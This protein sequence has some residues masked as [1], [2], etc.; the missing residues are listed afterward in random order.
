[1]A[2]LVLRAA[3]AAIG[4]LF[5]PIGS[6]VGQAI[7]ALG[8]YAIDRALIDS[9]RRIEGPRLTGAR[10]FAAEEGAAIPRLYGEARLGGLLIWATRFEETR[11]TSRQGGKGGPRVSEYSY[12]ANVAFALCEGPIAGVRRVWADGKEIDRETVEM[13]VHTGTHDQP[14]DPLIEA[15]QGT[16]N[17]PAYRGTAYV[18]I[19]RF[20]LGAYGNRIPQ[21]QF[22]VLRPVASLPGKVKAVALIPGATEFGLAPSPAT[23][24]KRPGETDALNRHVLHGATDLSASLDEL[25]V[26]CP[27][28]ERVALVA[29][30]FGDDLR[31]GS[32]RVRPMVTG[33]EMEGFS[34]DW[35]VSSLGRGDAAVVSMH[36]GGSAYGG[37]PSD[38]SVMEA[39]AEIR[40]R[41][42][43]VALYPFIMMDIPTANTLP[44]PYGDPAQPAYPW[45][46]RI[47]CDPAPGRPG[48]ADKTGAARDQVEAFV[49]G[50]TPADFIAG[51][52]TIAFGGD[53]DDW[54]YRRFILHFAKLAAAAGGVDAF[55]IGTELR[56][57]TTLRDDE[58]AFP[59]VEALCALA[60]DVR[61][62]VGETTSITYGAD[63]SEYFGYHPADGSGDALFHLDALWAHDA[64]DAVGIDNY[65]PLSDWRDADYGG[66]NP[67]GLTEPYDPA[68]LRAAIAGGEGFDWY[69][70]SDAD[71]AARIRTPI[72]DGAYSKPWMFR[73]KDLRSWWSS[74]HFDRLGGVEAATATSWVPESKPIWFTELGCPAAD[75]APNQPNVFPDPKSVESAVPYFSD[76]GRSDIAQQRFFAVHIDHWNPDA[77]GFAGD[78][79]PVS[80]IYGGRMVDHERIYLW[81]WDARAFPAFPAR[82]D[83]WSDADNWHRGHWLNGRIASPEVGDV[84]NAILADHG[85]PP[86]ATRDAGGVLHGYVVADRGSPRAA[87]EPIADLFG[88]SV[89]ETPSG[90]LFARPGAQSG[91][92]PTLGE[93]VVPDDEATMAIARLPDHELPVEVVLGFRDRFYEHQ[94]L[95]A[96]ATRTGQES[97]RQHAIE[98]PGLLDPG[99]ARALSDDWI[100]RA[101]CER[102]TVRFALAAPRDDV[103]PGVLVRLP[104]VDPEAEF[105]VIGIEDGIVRQ[106]QARRVRRTA[107]TPWSAGALSSTIRLM[108]P[109]GTPFVAFLDLPMG[110]APGDDAEAQF[111]LAAWQKPWRMQLAFASPEETGF[112]LRGTLAQ[113][114]RIGTLTAPLA[115]SFSGRLDQG[116]SVLV[117][118]QDSETSSISLAQLLNGGN[119]AAVRSLSG[120]WEILQFAEAEE[121]SAGLWR[122]THMLRGQLGTEDAMGAGATE[123]SPLVIL[124]DAVEAAGLRVGEAGLT[125]NWR[126]GP[127]GY[128]FSGGQYLAT[129]ET[130][131]VRSRL[132]LSPVH[133]R[134]R[135]TTGEDLAISWIRR[136]R[137]DADS[138]GEGDIPLGEEAELYRLE[139]APVAGAPVRSVE[140]AS[141]AW[142]Y[143]SSAIADDFPVAPGAIEI[144]VRQKGTGV[145][146]GFPA[147][148]TVM[149]P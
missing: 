41:G 120:A 77:P 137:L 133:L 45:R 100:R 58:G 118:L 103:V 113:P 6:I 90:L 66:G 96:R 49:G 21:F 19:E 143:T 65:M 18:V 17:A 30:W 62:I 37:S 132:P 57:L 107:P 70:A 128:D 94:S 71:R 38:G 142:T 130:G 1:M 75:K 141:S 48:T 13:R 112:E 97:Y 139:I 63:W 42:L 105:L 87:I 40:A 140:L 61:A 83:L 123:G 25:Q 119:L 81:A 138:W 14:P 98:F 104:T 144:S 72:T 109:V 46:G 36:D 43:K 74:E 114:A 16:G 53:P 34:R 60:A 76:G 84:I 69:Y 93:L 136:G 148:R 106:V 121:V 92:L 78:G 9:T 101:W 108:P 26:L 127:S 102:E 31:A 68:G 124:D 67:D 86:A 95:T 56:G 89:C 24:T 8:G 115:G 64:I 50:A 15:R 27:G 116:G 73:Y 117:A 51:P 135:K 82:R 147:R 146:W 131:A 85:L 32:C 54:G 2:T 47:T 111:R 4:G 35:V 122:L 59:F 149:L 126:V 125:L 12:F 29:T 20:A 5:G 44:D 33:N 28:I 52:E 88:L 39:I 7:G 3:G 79:N 129:V 10:P 22:E 134:A 23:L 145:G 110:A 11:R 91:E 99:Q 55:L 80:G